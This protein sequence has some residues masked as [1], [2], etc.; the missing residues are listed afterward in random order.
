MNRRLKYGHCVLC[1]RESHLTFHH[2]IP[3]KL[4]KRRRFEKRYSKD[5]LNE[6]IMLCPRCHKGLHKLYSEME[7][8]SRLHTLAALQSDPS[9]AKHVA[10]VAKQKI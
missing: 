2:L 7:L 8:G 4:H 3:R 6:G 5:E 10:W 1:N 9:V